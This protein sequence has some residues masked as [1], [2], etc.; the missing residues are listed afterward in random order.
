MH[1][2]HWNWAA[3][4][5]SGH[6]PQPAYTGS[7]QRPDSRPQATRQHQPAEGLHLRNPLLMDYYS[8]NRPRRDGWLSWPC[9]LTDSG[10]FTHKVVTQPAISLVQVRES[11]PA[12]TGGLSTM[13]CHQ[14]KC[15]SCDETFND[16]FVV[17]WLLNEPVRLVNICWICDKNLVDYIFEPL[18][19]SM[20]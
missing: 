8:F 13:L 6:C 4:G 19:T 12:R 1:S 16:S 9:W 11:S 18:C 2:H 3:I 15:L 5:R 20:L 7:I 14:W 10:C 17:T